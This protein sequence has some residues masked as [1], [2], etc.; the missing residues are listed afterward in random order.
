MIKRN[1][2]KEAA[3]II[4]LSLITAF[5]MNFV[6]PKGISLVGQ[7]DPSKGVVSAREKR[8]VVL[9]ER[10]IQDISDAKAIFDAGSAV[11]VDARSNEEYLAGHVYGAVSFPLSSYEEII[12][13][14]IGQH[15]L[16]TALIVYC[17]GRECEDSHMLASL[18]F[19]E[20]YQNVRVMVD[21]F[22]LWQSKG[23]PVEKK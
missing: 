7:W 23:F 19:E 3:V 8:S 2:L 10:E 20:G 15:P 1:I 4:G 6:S 13:A 14:F 18:L 9:G 12:A 22:P 17:S 21:G 5:V 16:S 11:F